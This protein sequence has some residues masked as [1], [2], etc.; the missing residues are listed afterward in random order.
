[1]TTI[2]D[3]KRANST[4]SRPGHQITQGALSSQATVQLWLRE[5]MI[6]EAKVRSYAAEHG[7]Q[8]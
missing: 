1:M 5:I 3:V 4:A 6:L 7:V 8:L 2:A